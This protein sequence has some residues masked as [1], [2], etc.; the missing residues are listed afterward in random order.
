MRPF[1]DCG[2][3][4]QGLWNQTRISSGKAKMPLDTFARQRF[5]R[6]SKGRFTIVSISI[7]CL[8]LIVLCAGCF[9]SKAPE[10]D[11]GFSK[12][13]R[14]GEFAGCYLNRGET[15][16]GQPPIYLSQTIWPYA[17]LNHQLI[18][19]VRIDATSRDSLRA[20]AIANS[21]VVRQDDFTAGRDFTF[22]N[23]RITVRIKNEASAAEPSGNVFIGVA[24]EMTTLGLDSDGNGRAEE[25]VAAAGTAFLIIPVAG[26]MRDAARFKKGSHL[27]DE[28]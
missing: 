4:T 26:R 14:L 1:T 13:S 16:A 19:I 15:E 24:R 18:D 12:V 3:L 17:G 6:L 22:A 23:G 8:A 28:S 25:T 9:T 21:Q 10:G 5:L 11:L 20:T 2:R 7:I 27:C